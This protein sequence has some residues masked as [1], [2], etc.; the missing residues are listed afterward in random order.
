MN[1]LFTLIAILFMAT[2]Q[3]SY[4]QST[5]NPPAVDLGYYQF[6]RLIGI[7]PCNIF[8]LKGNVIDTSSRL[9]LIGQRF[10]V[11]AIRDGY[12][13]IKI[14]NYDT[15]LKRNKRLLG[16]D[17]PRFLGTVLVET[18][19][20]VDNPKTEGNPTQELNKNKNGAIKVDSTKKDD[21]LTVALKALTKKVDSLKTITNKDSAKKVALTKMIQSHKKK[22]EEKNKKF[23]FDSTELY[24]KV[25]L[26]VIQKTAICINRVVGSFSFGAINFPFKYR[27]TRGDWTGNANF[28]AAG[29]LTFR[30]KEY[31][32]CKYSW[33]VSYSIGSISLDGSSVSKNSSILADANN[34]STL[35]LSTGALLQYKSSI[36][37]GLFI[38][39]DQLTKLNQQT[40]DWQY[41]GKPWASMG[42]GLNI[43]QIGGNSAGTQASPIQN[44]KF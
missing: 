18:D 11:I 22:T 4:A 32:Q 39:W 28:G 26:E 1:R 43:F 14:L 38:G 24:F 8:G 16:I 34:L 23:D 5:D 19:D 7:K 44:T 9:N 30:H 6:T 15:L 17:L 21:S 37:I 33:V 13:I 41:Q 35:S 25:P 29:G 20:M 3:H 2:T 12:A 42:I 36:Q 10:N 27:Y 40:F 31:R